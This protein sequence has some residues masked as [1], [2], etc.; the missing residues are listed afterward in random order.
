MRAGLWYAAAVSICVLTAAS[1]KKKVVSD[2]QES[3]SY[4]GTYQYNFS[5]V[6]GLEKSDSLVLDVIGTSGYTAFF[7]PDSASQSYA[8]FCAHSGTVT[9]FGSN[10]TTFTPTTF[11]A[12]NCDTLR[13]A[14]GT[15][16]RTLG[17]GGEFMLTRTAGDSTFK[18]TLKPR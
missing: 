10:T 12:G 7:Y 13:V 11:E 17:S 2:S 8:A 15:F 16:T 4:I 6:I 5:T 1:C 14:R 3:L 9:N 18:F